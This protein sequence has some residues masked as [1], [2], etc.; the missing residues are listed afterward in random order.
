MSLLHVSPVIGIN[1]NNNHRSSTLSVAFIMKCFVGFVYLWAAVSAV[2]WLPEVVVSEPKSSAPTVGMLTSV[3]ETLQAD[4]VTV[5]KVID[6]LQVKYNQELIA[7]IRSSGGPTVN[8]CAKTNFFVR[9]SNA[10][11]TTL[12]DII[13]DVS[14]ELHRKLFG[15]YGVIEREFHLVIDQSQVRS[16]LRELRDLSRIAQNWA[17][18][19]VLKRRAQ[20]NDLVE[21]YATQIAILL[22]SGLCQNQDVL[23]ERFYRIIN[24]GL[25]ESADVI[26][27]VKIDQAAITDNIIKRALKLADKIYQVE[28]LALKNLVT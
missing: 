18:D 15:A 9:Q 26:N 8:H 20:W 27:Q 28:I 3:V 19:A 17:R 12:V 10:F 2:P 23:N 14:W 16:W 11:W 25:A 24:I 1:S 7:F 4:G 5:L 21:Q 22:Q 6:D 13:A